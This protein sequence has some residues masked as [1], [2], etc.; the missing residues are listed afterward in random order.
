MLFENTLVVKI[1]VFVLLKKL[2]FFI[3]ICIILFGHTC[4]VCKYSYCLEMVDT[5]HLILLY[6][7]SHR[8]ELHEKEQDDLRRS[9]K[10]DETKVWRHTFGS[11]KQV[12]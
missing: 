4:I 9:Q 6:C 2:N 12:V 11:S 8:Q 1:L 10:K 5:H 3:F 7:F